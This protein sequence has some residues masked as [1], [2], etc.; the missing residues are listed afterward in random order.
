VADEVEELSATEKSPNFP[1]A[2]ITRITSWVPTPINGQAT[3]DFTKALRSKT[4]TL[5]LMNM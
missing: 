2:I 3:L 1:A 5:E 4:F